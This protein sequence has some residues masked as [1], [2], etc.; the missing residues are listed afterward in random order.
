MDLLHRYL[1][2]ILQMKSTANFLCRALR[3]ASGH[4]IIGVFANGMFSLHEFYFS[5][6]LI[7]ENQASILPSVYGESRP[8]TVAV[9]RHCRRQFAR[10]SMATLSLPLSPTRWGFLRMESCGCVRVCVGGRAPCNLCANVPTT[11]CWD[12]QLHR[13]SS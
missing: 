1:Y 12:M 3:T 11:A 6:L 13:Q 5:D 8:T 9:R 7:T 4:L 2:L 10:D